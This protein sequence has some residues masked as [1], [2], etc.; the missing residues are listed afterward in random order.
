MRIKQNPKVISIK[1]YIQIFRD[2]RERVNSDFQLAV[3]TYVTLVLSFGVIP[4]AC[5]RFILGDYLL[6]LTEFIIT[7][8]C[9]S[10]LTYA[11]VK[12]DVKIAAH[13]M[14]IT[15]MVT[16]IIVAKLAGLV[17]GFWLLCCVNIVFALVKPKNALLII[18]PA[19]I[20]LFFLDGIFNSSVEK[21]SYFASI[22]T[23]TIL[24]Y[25]FSS[26]ISKQQNDL[27]SMTL[28]DS[29][30]G[31]G[32][33]RAADEELD[34]ALHDYQRTNDHYSIIALDIDHF[35]LINDTYG[36]QIGDKTLITLV[37][38]LKL[39]SRSTD[40][41]FRVGGE[42]FLIIGKL[43]TKKQ[44][45][46]YAEKIRKTIEE[47]HLIE[48]HKVTISIGATQLSSSDDVDSVINRADKALYQAKAQ[49]RNRVVFGELI[50]NIYE[51]THRS[52]QA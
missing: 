24:A 52:N 46:E 11:W 38:L 32:N 23:T 34:I 16:L 28:T 22:T 8:L 3:L 14:S 47:S 27:I 36:H 40:R 10:S 30:T 1:Q 13:I 31:A 2:A 25:L 35:K 15:I 18:C 42:E 20:S 21:L 29:L 4:I 43:N 37:A 19:L 45:I 44:T 7:I 41:V 9:L 51:F 26:H 48:N 49:G 5:Y 39:E 17:A 50:D 33:R 12:N 6:S